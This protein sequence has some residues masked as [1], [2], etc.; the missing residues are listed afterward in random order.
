MRS[1]A[2]RWHHVLGVAAVVLALSGAAMA[3]SATMF[4]QGLLRNP[5]GSA[6]PTG[7]YPMSVS[8]W[9]AAA[10][11]N[12]LWSETYP[13]VIVNGGSF[14]VQLGGIT[15]FGTL[16]AD[17]SALWLEVAADTGAGSEVYGNRVR[18][19]SV[20]YARRAQH[21]VEADTAA[22]ATH[23]TSADSATNA[24]HAV[25]AGSAT[26]ATNATSATSATNA[27]N[28]TNA[29]NADTV[30]GLHASGLSLLSHN[31]SGADIVSGTISTDR[32][33]SY[34]E[35]VNESRIGTGAVQVAAGDHR[36]DLPYFIG[37]AGDE[38]TGTKSLGTVA[39]SGITNTGTA[40]VAPLNG[41]Y[42]VHFQQLMRVDAGTIYVDM[43]LNNNGAS[44]LLYGWFNAGYMEDMIVSRI[45][46]MNAGDTISFYIRGSAGETWAGA[47]SVVTMWLIG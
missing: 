42:F 24:A 18:L 14:A 28:A 20:P 23:A 29:G 6:V 3:D 16:F 45:V 10:A 27:T 46:N 26:N 13:A 11:G 31:H 4:Y 9:D 12:Q 38:R 19:A 44:P 25:S 2:I 34:A 47:H 36:H 8:I 41:R 37:Q 15:P 39:A 22:L 1:R 21:A 33:S 17:N 5:D 35:L 32:F 40:L 30:D 43:L 7:N